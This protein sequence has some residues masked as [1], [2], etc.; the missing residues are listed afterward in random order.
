[1][2]L[3]S[4][5][6]I[7]EISFLWTKGSWE[8]YNVE[9]FWVGFLVLKSLST[10]VYSSRVCWGNSQ[11]CLLFPLLS[12]FLQ[13]GN[14]LYSLVLHT[15]VTIP[16][17]SYHCEVQ[18]VTAITHLNLI[19]D[20]IDKHAHFLLVFSTNSDGIMKDYY[21]YP[22]LFYPT[23]WTQCPDPQESNERRGTQVENYS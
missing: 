4:K 9:L 7:K 12:C 19:V 6:G 1:M 20:W 22:K 8:S 17:I 10:A 13:K 15:E 14:V 16:H 18:N 2:N 3:L 21:K 11:G 5:L 23:C